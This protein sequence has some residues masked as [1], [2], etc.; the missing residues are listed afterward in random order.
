MPLSVTAMDLGFWGLLLGSIVAVFNA[1]CLPPD[2]V[3]RKQTR[4]RS[5][6]LERSVPSQRSQYL[7]LIS[8][9]ARIV[10][11]TI[12]FSTRVFRLPRRARWKLSSIFL[13]HID[14]ED[15]VDGDKGLVDGY[16]EEG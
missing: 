9:P 11:H 12:A 5:C 2:D 14:A 15:G 13:F 6:F 7:I 3:D 10:V 4:H 1:S 8:V 16:G